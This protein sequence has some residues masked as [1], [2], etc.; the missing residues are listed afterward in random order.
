[1]AGV[2]LA[3]YKQAGV[4]FERMLALLPGSTP[5]ALVR[6]GP[7]YLSGDLPNLPYIPRGAAHRLE[8]LDV[9][10]LSYR[11]P[12]SGRGIQH[13]SL[14]LERGSFTVITG[15][16]GSGKSTLLRVLL[17]LLPKDAGEIRWNGAIVDDSAAFFIP[18]RAAYTPQAPRLFST[19]LRDNI[20]LGLPEDSVELDA[21]LA[22]G[23]METDV[24]TL[25]RGLD[26]VVGPRGV[27]L[28]GGQVQRT[29]AARMFVRDA[30]LL[31]FDDLSSALDVETE[32]TLWERLFR[33]RDVTCLV[34]SHQ[35]AALRRAD[36]IVV[37]KEGQIEAEGAL[38]ELLATSEEM[39]HLWSGAAHADQANEPDA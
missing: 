37:L 11:Y 7:V 1:L 20:L 3:R 33:Q 17:G 19:T 30:E 2:L 16:I 35:R 39:R 18:P 12:D 27:K 24:R 10:G 26:T 25:E 29:A 23:V 36:R 22:L 28:S 14:H 6:H 32:R 9:S 4:A 5:E 21:A 13:I 38:D 31:V 34:V 8:R 15:R